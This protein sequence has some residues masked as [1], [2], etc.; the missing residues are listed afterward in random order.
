MNQL[1]LYF[2]GFTWLVIVRHNFILSF[3]VGAAPILLIFI[4]LALFS[5]YDEVNI[6]VPKS[7]NTLN[8]RIKDEENQN[9]STTIESLENRENNHFLE[10][11]PEISKELCDIIHYVID[12]YVMNW[13]YH[14]NPSQ[15]SPFPKTVELILKSIVESIS[16]NLKN[17]DMTEFF[18]L[19]LIPI[20]NLHFNA[21]NTSVKNIK[22]N[23]QSSNIN[24]AERGIFQNTDLELAV[25]FNNIYRIH[26]ALSLRTNK[27]K[28][29]ILNYSRTISVKLLSTLLDDT[30]LSSPLISSLIR[31]IVAT[32]LLN[33]LLSKYSEPDNWNE[34]LLSV[35]KNILKERDQVYEIKK[36]L[37]KE[38]RDEN[39]HNEEVK[40]FSNLNDFPRLS[41]DFTEKQFETFLKCLNSL[42]TK[43][44]LKVLQLQL[45]PCLLKINR[46]P[47]LTKDEQIFQKRLILSLNLI[48]S[49]LYIIDPKSKRA[50]LTLNS[51]ASTLDDSSSSIDTLLKEFEFIIKTIS[52][53]TI[54]LDKNCITYFFEYLKSLPTNDGE[55]IL[56]YWLTVKKIKNPLENPFSDTFVATLSKADLLN[57]WDIKEKYFN[58]ENNLQVM[59]KINQELTN[60]IQYTTTDEEQFCSDTD[61]SSLVRKSILLLQIQSETILNDKYFENFKKSD[62]FLKMVSNPNFN[63][64]E[65]YS[66]FFKNDNKISRSRTRKDRSSSLV[67]QKPQN[68]NAVK[69]FTNPNLNEALDNILHEDTKRV[70]KKTKS[71]ND[72][73][74]G[75]DNLFNNSTPKLFEDERSKVYSSPNILKDRNKS[76]QSEMLQKNRPV[77]KTSSSD[78]EFIN[79]VTTS[80]IL[81]SVDSNSDS[82]LDDM[83]GKNSSQSALNADSDVDDEDIFEDNKSLIKQT[84]KNIN[85]KEEIGNLTISMDQIEKELNL[86]KHLLLKAEL[87]NSKEQLHILQKS[88]RSLTR[89]L[90][91]KDLLKQQYIVQENAKS[92]YG[93]TKLFIRS[94][95]SDDIFDDG[96]EIVY[97]LITVNYIINGQLKTWEVARRF[98]EFVKLNSH[99]KRHFKKLVYHLQGKDG[100][101]KKVHVSL[102]YHISKTLLYDERK[103]KLENYL[104]Q[105]LI[106]PEICEDDFLK[107][108]LTN[109]GNFRDT[110]KT[111]LNNVES[112]NSDTEEEPRSPSEAPS[113]TSSMSNLLSENSAR[114]HL[115]SEPL[116]EDTPL[117][118][119][120][121]ASGQTA[122]LSPGNDDHN[123]TQ[124]NYDNFEAQSYKSRSFI[125]PISD[126]FINIFSLNKFNSGW[127]RGRAVVVLIQQLFGSTTEKY[128]RDSFRRYTTE[129]H[130][131]EELY[132]LKVHLW[133]LDGLKRKNRQKSSEVSLE[134]T[135]LELLKNRTN[136]K[137]MFQTL[138]IELCG[139][140]VGGH[141]SKKAS[142]RIHDMLQNSYLNASLLFEILDATLDEFIFKSM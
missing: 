103:S 32:S 98:S 106:I 133:G 132:R 126:L 77:L 123:F 60:N 92:L 66:L 116:I 96:N 63:S 40:S 53:D 6:V 102:K 117:R 82:D 101:P 31:E 8:T 13:F 72:F 121:I 19:R 131:A 109:T 52:L 139:R 112:N 69:I 141:R 75:E 46:T 99:L 22:T 64:N 16:N 80:P 41:I 5:S 37:S 97:Y 95:F 29:D 18:I 83:I 1:Y 108:F 15:D 127:L 90:I 38:I 56:E 35:S 58:Q 130:I 120:S 39:F 25:E 50:S 67:D 36:I 74:F 91:N 118:T 54:L 78:P 107:K 11:Y 7:L 4:Y 3:L 48:K 136:S 79:I 113:M 12:D 125:K 47:V 14:L 94:Y 137:K 81:T 86:L 42:N 62:F 87:T 20:F 45:I 34:L 88:Q 17:N 26:S 33:P 100:F 51:T 70:H 9:V 65:L 115:F 73:L 2:L 85:F 124:I 43:S 93:K 10:D 84:S 138:M 30:D 76:T 114:S 135:K 119:T 110:L 55:I 111:N 61:T 21:Y 129:Q 59:N 57:I 24:L 122:P 28:Q 44:D 142:N 27:L 89:E 140:V 23:Q 49:K 104:R 105:L 128:I 68:V 71:P 134:K